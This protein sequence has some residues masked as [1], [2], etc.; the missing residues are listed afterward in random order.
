MK[1]LIPYLKEA[2]AEKDYT[3]FV[4][5]EDGLNGNIDLSKWVGR[6]VFE[7][8][9]E[10]KNFRE[11]RITAERK[12]EWNEDIDM[13]PDAFYLQL[14]KKTF[15]DYAGDQQLLRDSY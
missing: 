11:F 8:W 2:R 14:S 9:S 1:K 5:F 15:S 7:Y 3:L 13:D 4:L 12:L 6:G 10:E